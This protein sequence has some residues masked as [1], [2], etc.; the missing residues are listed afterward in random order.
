LDYDN[1]IEEDEA[2]EAFRTQGKDKKGTDGFFPCLIKHHAAKTYWQV[3]AK[4]HAFLTSTIYKEV[5]G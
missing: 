4:L 1:R 2:V 5:R 3:E